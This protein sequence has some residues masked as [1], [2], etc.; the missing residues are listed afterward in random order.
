MIT[1]IQSVT[2]YQQNFNLDPKIK[3]L[4]SRT[5]KVNVCLL[6]K[7]FQGLDFLP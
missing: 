3:H 2:E 7:Q 1:N 4:N 5:F 6:S